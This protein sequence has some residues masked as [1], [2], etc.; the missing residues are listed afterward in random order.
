[1]WIIGLFIVRLASL[2]LIL[3]D[4]LLASSMEKSVKVV[5]LIVNYNY[6]CEVGYYE[7]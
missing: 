4:F 1:M 3:F 7:F 5:E 2:V 6:V